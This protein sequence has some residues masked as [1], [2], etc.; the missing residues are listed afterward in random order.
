[1]HL[2]RGLER[3]ACADVY[4]KQ[5]LC[6]SAYTFVYTLATGCAYAL[7][8]VHF[9]HSALGNEGEG[10]Q[11]VYEST[12]CLAWGVVFERRRD[13]GFV[14]LFSIFNTG[15][16]VC[17]CMCVYTH[18]HTHTAHMGYSI[19]SPGVGMRHLEGLKNPDG[20]NLGN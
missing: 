16:S 12:C 9:V 6:A 8:Y 10:A 7:M 18:T 14:Y 20:Q 15:G 13:R 1:M 3:H 4:V 19:V 17:G 2:D 5:V 11:L